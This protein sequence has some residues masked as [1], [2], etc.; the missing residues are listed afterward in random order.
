MIE[1]LTRHLPKGK[2]MRAIILK[3]EGYGDISNIRV[4]SVS[5]YCGRPSFR[6]LIAADDSIMGD[7]FHARASGFIRA[8]SGATWYKN[9][10]DATKTLRAISKLIDQPATCRKGEPWIR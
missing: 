1:A 10:T 4:Q 5:P 2:I 6:F 3:T 7:V 9:E 8:E